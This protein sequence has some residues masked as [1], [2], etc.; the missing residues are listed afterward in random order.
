MVDIVLPQLDTLSLTSQ[1][2]RS[3]TNWPEA[4]VED[5]LATLRS[6]VSYAESIISIAEFA[7]AEADRAAQ[8][9]A[10]LLNQT[11][12]RR[13]QLDKLARDVEQ[14]LINYV[15]IKGL[16]LQMKG[17][18]AADPNIVNSYNV[19]SLTRTGT[20]T[21]QITV[22][23]NTFYGLD[24]FNFFVPVFS[25][26][27]A[28]SA[29]SALYSV[30]VQNTG[31]FTFNISVYAITQGAG[32]TLARTLY[33]LQTTDNVAISFVLNTGDGRLPPP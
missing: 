29:T 33:D 30:D 19:A 27:I 32:T 6:I 26:V 15:P 10:D 4:M 16:M 31:A 22:T 24:M 12:K 21:Y 20:G 5:Y 11:Q 25:W 17:T 2:V 7:Q 14:A 8:V 23:Q 18:G 9:N 3:M 1:E 13:A 28:P